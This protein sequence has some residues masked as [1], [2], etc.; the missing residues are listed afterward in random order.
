MNARYIIFGTGE[1]GKRIV[2]GLKKLQIPIEG[3]ADNNRSLWGTIIDGH[4]VFSPEE[5]TRM[6]GIEIVI[7]V[8]TNAPVKLQLSLLS[9]KYKTFPELARK[10]PDTFLPYLAL[11]KPQD[12]LSIHEKCALALKDMESVKEFWGQLD[13]RETLDYS[14]LP[15]HRPASET[16]FPPD[17]LKLGM[18]EVFVDCG[19]YDGCTI[20]ELL[21]RTEGHSKMIYAFEPDKANYDKLIEN[22]FSH[23]ANLNNLAVSGSCGT[24]PFT[25]GNGVS[26][27]VEESK[28]FVHCVDLD[29]FGFSVPPTFIKMDIE[30]HELEALRGATLTIQK[31]KPILAICI[32]HKHEHLWE[33][34]LL[35]KEINPDYD[36]FIRRYSDECWELVCYAIPK[37]RLL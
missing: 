21:K 20:K 3:F 28:N 30:G 8:Y 5:L 24:V 26:S 34:P 9:L 22:N 14:S 12:P 33:I 29:S 15:P 13:W 11:P 10:Y 37:G 4:C 25:F 27:S 32:Y 1:L 35:I 6:D 23:N 2:A 18:D 31:H 19:A 17:L 7:G 16:Y 36:L